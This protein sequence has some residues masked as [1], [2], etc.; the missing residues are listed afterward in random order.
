[1]KIVIRL[2]LDFLLFF[3]CCCLG[4]VIYSMYTGKDF[5]WNFNLVYGTFMAVLLAVLSHFGRK[6]RD[7]A[8]Q[9]IPTDA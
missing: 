3:I 6:L 4:G 7:A 8:Q 1:M 5:D 2:I 9:K